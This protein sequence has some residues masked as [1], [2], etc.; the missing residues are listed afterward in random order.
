MRELASI[1]GLITSL[2]EASIP[3]LDRGFLYGD[4]VFE[5]LR[6]YAGIPHA[7][8]EHIERLFRS[9]SLIGM[10]PGVTR[11]L[12]AQEVREAIRHCDASQH[13]VR[14]VLTRGQGPFGLSLRGAGQSLRVVLVRALSEPDPRLYRDGLRIE[15]VTVPPSRFVAGV[16]PS[17]YLTNLLALE[18]AQSL[19]AHDA[20]LLG[21]YGELLEGATSSVFLVRAGRVETPTLALGIL[22]G[23]TRNLALSLAREQ[24][25]SAHERL[26][27]IHDAYRAQEVFVTSSVREI[28]PVVAIDG[29][30]IGDACPGPITTRLMAAYHAITRGSARTA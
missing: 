26:L 8:D 4:A 23:I 14:I 9:S 17:S 5:A 18:H 1:D 27:T 24:G 10:D 19:G 15:T 25:L 20:F 16:K 2:D 12:V 22:P 30:S 21:E 6:T 29:V 28:A 7:L 13:Y 11:E 3:V